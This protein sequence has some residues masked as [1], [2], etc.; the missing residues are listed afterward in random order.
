MKPT[1]SRKPIMTILAGAVLVIGMSI[2]IYST[3]YGGPSSAAYAAAEVIKIPVDGIVVDA[4]AADGAGEE[5]HV[6]GKIHNVVQYI[7][8]SAG[9]FH[10]KVHSN[11]QGV[12]GTGLT[13]G[14]KYQA[15]GNLDFEING[16][17]GQDRTVAEAISILFISQG[18]GNNF[19]L[20]GTFH[21][22]V[23]ADGIVTAFVDNFRAE[24]K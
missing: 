6:T 12:S 16:K 24:C 9:G 20:H 18:N 11:Y 10:L 8:D 13:T 3:G 2:T 15:T 19:L 17:V 14:D 22:T 23:N 1:K 5:V 7:F 4:C 21:M